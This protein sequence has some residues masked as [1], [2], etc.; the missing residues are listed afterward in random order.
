MPRH[1]L[2]F[3]TNNKVTY[4]IQYVIFSNLNVFLQVCFFTKDLQFLFSFFDSWFYGHI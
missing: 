3:E 2:I 4:F 1:D